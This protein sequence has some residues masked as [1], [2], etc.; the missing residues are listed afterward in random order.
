MILSA[1]TRDRIKR[2]TFHK[3][4]VSTVKFRASS[5]KIVSS[6]R[7]KTIAIWDCE[8]S[9]VPSRILRG[10]SHSVRDVA[11]SGDGAKI[12]SVSND[13]NFIAWKVSGKDSETLFTSLFRAESVSAH[14][15]IAAI[16]AG[17]GRLTVLNWI[18]RETVWESS[19]E[20]PVTAVTFSPNGKYL[21]FGTKGNM[22]RILSTSSW[23]SICEP[24]KGHGNPVACVAF[25]PNSKLFA[26]TA[27]DGTIRF[28]DAET[29]ASLGLLRVFHREVDCISF[30]PDGARIVSGSTDG[31]IRTWIVKS[32]L[33]TPQSHGSQKKEEVHQFAL[34]GDGKRVLVLSFDDKMTMWDALN[35]HPIFELGRQGDISCISL[36]Y[37][38]YQAAAGFN[39]GTIQVFYLLR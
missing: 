34:S 39:D 32:I 7:D 2:L 17:G 37:W 10:H 29:G 28:W 13:G 9:N 16:A 27:H 21:V 18:R 19:L 3:A 22:V 8:S 36:D 38:G 25:S 35:G 1:S 11:V 4:E 30:S 6:S 33:S 31:V 14:C 12:F 15:Q 20:G 24:L 5:S 26:S 23:A